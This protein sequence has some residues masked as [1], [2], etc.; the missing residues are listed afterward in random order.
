[1][2]T[3]PDWVSYNLG[4]RSLAAKDATS[5]VARTLAGG[6]IDY[7]LDVFCLVGRTGSIDDDA[8]YR[9]ACGAEA[10]GHCA[11][12]QALAADR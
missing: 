2:T 1:M 12:R 4:V 3:A 6:S 5:A 11:H 8:I 10:I 7:C 9:A